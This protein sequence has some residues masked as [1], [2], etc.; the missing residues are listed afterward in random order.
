[1]AAGKALLSVVAVAEIV[2]VDRRQIYDWKEQW[3]LG[4]ADAGARLSVEDAIEL[5]ALNFLW[6]ALGATK[7]AIAYEELRATVRKTKQGQ[8]LDFVW[9]DADRLAVVVRS[10]DELFKI[11]VGGRPIRLMSLGNE[12]QRVRAAFEREARASRSG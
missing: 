1:V 5:S 9:V 3:G 2:Q 12:M 11:A 10:H 7:A 6:Q 8:R 4:K